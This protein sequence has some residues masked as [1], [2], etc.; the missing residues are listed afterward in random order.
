MAQADRGPIDPSWWRWS[1]QPREAIGMMWYDGGGGWGG[2]I[3]MTAFM[4]LLWAVLIL[5]LVALVRYLAGA[6]RHQQ[7]GSPPTTVTR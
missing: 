5:G 3:V 2:W 7:P 1:H 4:V 6:R